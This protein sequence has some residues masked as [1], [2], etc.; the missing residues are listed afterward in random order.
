MIFT[1][2]NLDGFNHLFDTAARLAKPPQRMKRTLVPKDGPKLRLVEAA[3]PLFSDNG[4]DGVSVRDVT[5]AAAANVAAVNYHFGSREGLVEVVMARNLEPIQEQ[6]LARLEAAEGRWANQAV[7]LEE[8]VDA[9]VRP[10]VTQVEKSQLPEESYFRLIGRILERDSR[11]MPSEIESRTSDLNDRFIRSIS[12][13]L[14][15]VAEEDLVWRLHFVTGAMIHML[16]HG[17][18]MHETSKG[19]GSMPGMATTMERFQRF[20]VAG[21]RNGITNLPSCDEKDEHDE[22]PQGEEQALDDGHDELPQ[23]EEQGLEDEHGEL[24]QGEEQA[25]DDGHGEPPQGEEQ[26]LDDGHDELP[27]GEE[28]AL[29]DEHGELPQGEEQGLEGEH[30]EPPQGEEQALDD[31]HGELAQG[32]EQ[33][34]EDEHGELAQGEEQGLDD[35]HDEP[36]Q[37]EEQALDDGHD[38][39][40]QG[41]EQGTEL[42][43]ERKRVKKKVEDD[44]QVMFEF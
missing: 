22:L 23:G 18:L 38:E 7:P 43:P 31:G 35:E 34:L 32:E 28:Q 1:T 40:P 25:L 14:P 20:A 3:E 37:G 42:K 4:F 19:A 6:R 9:F 27:Q 13:I 2:K 36:P 8:V 33:A 30:G 5:Q 44:P 10:L 29:E 15:M 41:E 39:P 12:K 26:A 17:D 24:A 21:I 11:G 16:T